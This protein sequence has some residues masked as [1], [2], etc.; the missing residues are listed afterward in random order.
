MENGQKMGTLKNK[1]FTG[2]LWAQALDA[3]NDNAYKVAVC[4]V[5][6]S[7]IPEG[8]GQ[9]L[10]ISAASAIY[11]LPFL[12]VSSFAGTL[13]DRYS[14]TVIIQ[15]V[16]AGEIAVMGIGAAGFLIGQLPILFA[17][18][19]LMGAQS[20]ML[21]P[22]KYGIIPELVQEP[23]LARANGLVEATTFFAI[24]CGT[25]FG[26]MILPAVG[27]KQVGWI[28]VLVSVLGTIST[29]FIPRTPAAAPNRPI[30]M[31]PVTEV[32]R[33]IRKTVRT[34]AVFAPIS[35]LIY[36]WFLGALLQIS[37]LIFAKQDLGL[38]DHGTGVLLTALA[39][40][41]GAGSLLAGRLSDRKIELGLIPIGA[42]GLAAFTLD[43]GFAAQ[44]APRAAADL[45]LLGLFGGLFIVPLDATLQHKSDPAERGRI[46]A[47]SNFLVF[48]GILAASGVYT[49]LADGLGISVSG[50]LRF[51]GLLT[52]AVAVYL[53][54]RLGAAVLR[55][56][57]LILTKTVFDIQIR[58]E[59]NI[60]HHGPAILAANH[61][62]YVDMLLVGSCMQRMIRFLTLREYY[63]QPWFK[64]FCRLMRSI[65][66]TPG[67]GAES[68]ARAAEELRAGKVICIFPE[69]QISRTGQ[70]LGFRR[71]IE[72]LAKESGASIVPVH[73]DGM[74]G[75]PFTTKS[76][77]G[78]RI[79]PRKFPWRVTISFG[80]AFD[81][82]ART[83][84]VR[85]EVVRLGAD[86]AAANRRRMKTT[87]ADRFVAQACAHWRRPAVSDSTGR[88]MT[89]GELLTAAVLLK[90]AIDRRIP[91]KCVGILMP[92]TAG[93]AAVNLA[94]ALCGRTAVN[95]N[96]TASA[97]AM[98]SAADQ[99][100]LSKIISSRAFLEK[101][102]LKAPVDVIFIEDL[103]SSVSKLRRAS[104]YAVL[105]ILP[106]GLIARALGLR[107]IRPDDIAAVL[108]SSGSTGEPKGVMLTHANILANAGALSELF[109]DDPSECILGVL[110]FFHSFGLT[111]TL[112]YPLLRGY[113]AVYHP[114]PLDGRT[115][116]HLARQSRATFLV[117][118][119]TFCRAYLRQ[120]P[121]DAFS[122]LKYLLVGAERLR[123]ELRRQLEETYKVNV[124]E[125]YGATECSPVVSVNIP[126]LKGPGL[127]QR[128]TKP[129]SV[130]RAIPGVAVKIVDP[131]SGAE[132]DQGREGLLLVYG[133]NVMKG[134]W[135]DPARTAKALRDGWY[136]TGDMAKLDP[137]GFITLTGRLSRFAKIGGEMVPLGQ[138]E[139]TLHE[140]IGSAEQVLAVTS[141][142]DESRGER[143]AVI[144]VQ[145]IEAPALI[146]GLKERGYPNLW[147]PKPGD[148]IRTNSMPLL[149]SGKLDLLAMRRLAEDHAR[150][151]V[152]KV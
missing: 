43:L 102:G 130:G 37:L 90:S 106:A 84:E 104:T 152:V 42:L 70:I 33:T 110:P 150:A 46:L 2:Y 30:V 4:L 75:G 129:G 56:A 74:R 128:G 135:N 107:R 23:L 32:F 50:V 123:P 71:G 142:A 112:W 17:A 141:V 8:E 72:L 109:E 27:A 103:V 91:T 76:G 73:L 119:P 28:F 59:D 144:H 111:G 136:V 16:K 18:L 47:A 41:I 11:I 126:D 9:T 65:P 49:L 78:L 10:W 100:G 52:A 116:G 95:L 64:P 98:K 113:Q 61:V 58:G 92:T 118:T 115:I 13:A 147:I 7:M 20:A 66:I 96:F 125:G 138:I 22:A 121:A 101:T 55:F 139:D 108:F 146:R 6:L 48:S 85:S 83:E 53:T 51:T 124:L 151:A 89:Y 44:N 81:P 29:R 34:P 137:E 145:E 24:V 5:V 57:A 25:A 60:P 62:S 148:F 87:L 35:G 133:P 14:K 131:E 122:E 54:A 114:N 99:C 63:D 132:L 31:N 93:A 79:F 88:K 21:S 134:Y 140:L 143:L 97:D 69:G 80:K 105:G 3:F 77:G 40:G 12:L 19:F 127:R 1:G 86:A 82:G 149:G 67:D 38:G 94:A 68:L 117:A 15:W 39:V 26:G 36:F 120:I 45:F